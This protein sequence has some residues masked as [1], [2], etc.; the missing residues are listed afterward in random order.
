MTQPSTSFVR[1]LSLWIFSGSTSW[2]QTCLD[3]LSLLV[4]FLF[5]ALSSCS[6]DF[7]LAY[8]WPGITGLQH[9]GYLWPLGIP[10]KFEEP[11]RK[12]AP[13]MVEPHFLSSSKDL[14]HSPPFLWSVVREPQSAAVFVFDGHWIIVL[15]ALPHILNASERIWMLI[16]AGTPDGTI[17]IDGQIS[18]WKFIRRRS[19]TRKW[20]VPVTWPQI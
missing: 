11:W 20:A 4:F 7:V 3:P 10:R 15:Q 2:G 18:R 19:A 12:R 13:N 6:T 14:E 16:W 8:Q 5:C 9:P 1:N 17:P